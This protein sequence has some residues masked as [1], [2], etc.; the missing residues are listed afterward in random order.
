MKNASVVGFAGTPSQHAA[1]CDAVPVMRPSSARRLKNLRALVAEFSARDIGC[2]GTA[3]FLGCSLSAARNY[4]CELLDAA[5]VASLPVRQAAG[6]VDRTLYRLTADPLAVHEFLAGL[7]RSHGEHA[8]PAPRGAAS[9]DM[10][11][12]PESAHRTWRTADFTLGVGE[13]PARRDPL[14]AALFGMPRMS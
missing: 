2:A 6:C 5:V 13:G 14:V 12:D 4:I 8:M 11:P 9:I 7:A 1:E 10:S 3:L